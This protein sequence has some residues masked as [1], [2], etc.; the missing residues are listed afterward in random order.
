[1]VYFPPGLLSKIVSYLPPVHPCRCA[2]RC[3]HRDTLP[4]HKNCLDTADELRVMLAERGC[5]TTGTKASLVMRLYR[6][7]AAA[8]RPFWDT[9]ANA[10]AIRR[11]GPCPTPFLTFNRCLHDGGAWKA[12]LDEISNFVL[13]QEHWAALQVDKLSYYQDVRAVS[14]MAMMYKR[15]MRQAPPVEGYRLMRSSQGINPLYLRE[16]I[17]VHVSKSHYNRNYPGGRDTLTVSRGPGP[18]RG[19]QVRTLQLLPN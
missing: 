11:C 13:S 14:R 3:R 6:A 12:R 10:K 8:R 7:G 1:M 17:S 18:G 5:R 15:I 19:W 2:G 4:D 9:E 16:N